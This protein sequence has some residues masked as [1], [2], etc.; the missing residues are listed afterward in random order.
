MNKHAFEFNSIRNITCPDDKQAGRLVYSGK[1]P[2][3]SFLQIPDDENVREYLVEA[4]GKKKQSPSQV[5]LRIRETLRE[6]PQDF[7]VL[8]NGITIIARGIEIDDATRRATLTRPSIING[9][10]TQGELRRFNE[11]NPEHEVFVTY[12]I[13]VCDDDDLIADISIARNFQ[14]D[15]AAVS[16]A[17]RLGQFDELERRLQDSRPEVKLKKSETDR[18]Q[19][20]LDSEKLI[21]VLTALIPPELWPRKEEAPNK[22][23]SYS[24]KSQCLKQF[25]E[26]HD[27]A[28]SVEKF[29][30]RAR[31]LYDFY[32][33]IAVDAWSLYNKWKA[34]QAFR[35]NRLRAIERDA[36]GK[37]LDVP[38][39]I[40]FPIIAAHAVFV[41]K[42]S[43]GWKLAVP[44]ALEDEEL[45]KIATTAYIEIAGSNPG[46]MGKNRACY[47]QLSQYTTLFNRL[48]QRG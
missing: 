38:D 34:H 45:A 37:V 10:Q 6:R 16:I 26:T 40:V 42:S 31:Q 19:E 43:T 25:S 41:T 27:K 3:T 48:A 8:N 14:N 28:T 32:L 1:A 5:H 17:G 23:V 9:S 15:V 7:C 18:S 36:S 12:E 46:T 47:S 29:D 44:P 4:Q 33:D 22:T 2:H 39:G 13:V 30:A 21:Q 11:K 20:Y 35:G 24:G